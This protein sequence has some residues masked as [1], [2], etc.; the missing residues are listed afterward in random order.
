MELK[1]IYQP[2][3]R[4]LTVVEQILEKNLKGT[5]HKS[6]LE[7][8]DY[9]LGA[10]SKRLRPALVILSAKASRQSTSFVER[11]VIS[12]AAAM[13]LIHAASLIHDDVIDHASLRHNKPTINSKYGQDV[14]IALGDYLY[15]IG[16]ELISSCRNTDILSCVSQATKAMCEG[17]LIQVCER[18]NLDLLRKRYYLIV[19]KK[20][21]SLFVAS[22]Q[23]GAMLANQ[24]DA[25]HRALRG[26]GLNF[27]I[28]FQIIDDC[29]DL[30]GEEDKLGKSPGADFRMG[31][32]TL[33]VLNLLSQSKDKN[34]LIHLLRQ[35]ERPE[36]F[37][38]IKH[39]FI[40]SAALLK[41]REDTSIYIQKAK[42][43]L[44]RLEDSCFKQGLSAL[45][46][47]IIESL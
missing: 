5:T 4:E 33:P 21:A 30:I 17:E 44:C 26:Y 36:V 2:I 47:F 31:E 9:L 34:R 35:T 43:H 12:V 14:S 6:I 8:G 40:N 42:K 7:I 41:T 32:L 45:A 19:K 22:C 39:R 11:S 38:E 28:A 29:L 18:D 27:G 3:R 20:T 46:D 16:F 1:E 24:N 10:K 23:A 15:S 13:E 25:V 37:K